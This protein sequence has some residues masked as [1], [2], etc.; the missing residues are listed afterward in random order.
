LRQNPLA[1]PPSLAHESP[2]LSPLFAYKVRVLWSHS[3]LSLT[4]GQG[5][6]AL[7]FS[8]TF[9]YPALLDVAE[10]VDL[11]QDAEEHRHEHVARP[12]TVEAARPSP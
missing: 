2:V 3:P 5:I 10:Q 8:D 12:T 7:P 1:E 4:A 6:V 11:S 9:A